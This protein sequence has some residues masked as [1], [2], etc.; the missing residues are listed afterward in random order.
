[1]P[2]AQGRIF[3]IPPPREILVGWGN[4]DVL[5]KNANVRGKKSKRGEKRKLFIVLGRKNMNLEKR[6][7]GANISTIL[8]IYTPAAAITS[9]TRRSKGF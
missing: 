2:A 6:G 7:G 3:F 4:D 1:M 8:L 5:R 9:N